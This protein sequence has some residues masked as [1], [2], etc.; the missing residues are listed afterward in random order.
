M[1]ME[2]ETYERD[3]TCS[4]CEHKIPKGE[5]HIR[6]QHSVVRR[7]SLTINICMV[8]LKNALSKISKKEYSSIAKRHETK[9]I[10]QEISK[11]TKN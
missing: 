8:C 7:G 10:L 2:M 11:W 3:R 4:Y 9:E 6:F 5:K 1:E